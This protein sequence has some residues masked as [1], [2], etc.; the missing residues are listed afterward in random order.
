DPPT[1]VSDAYAVN[2]DNTLTVP[3]G[4]V[5]A[6]DSDPDG[7]PLTAVL[8]SGPAHGALTLNADGS[9]TY[10]PD[11]NFNGTDSFSYKANDG[12][13]DSNTTTVTINVAAVNDPPQTH[14]DVYSVAEDTTLAVAPA[15]GVLANDTDVEN[16]PLT[17]VLVGGPQHGTVT[18]NADGSFTYVPNPNF[19]G[20]DGFAY[21]A[22]DG[23][24]DSNVATVTITV[25]PVND[26]PAA[27]NDSY[28]TDEDTPLVVSTGGLLA[29]DTDVDGDPLTSILVDTPQHGT[30]TLNA[31]GTF[32][33]T[34]AA[35]Y[36]GT[37]GFT[38]KANDGTVDSN[39]AAVTITVNPVND[40]PAAINDAYTT[41]EDT[42][43]V[44]STG[45]VLANDT[46]VDGD[47]LTSILVDS[48]QHGTVTLNADGT[49]TYTSAANYNGTDGF[50]YKANDGAADSNV[51]AVTITINP[52]NDPPAAVNDSYATDED[53]PLVVSSGGVLANDTDVEG[54]PLTSILVDTPQ[55]GTVTLN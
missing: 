5:L 1:A 18:L 28:A 9:F 23:T 17:A 51:A 8:A 2:E 29:N 34:P 39:V 49:F 47:S 25:N 33:Y 45:G 7:D 15:M 22:N 14:N 41:D 11:A 53:T 30:V 26:P 20:T 24:D 38:Y 48:P 46:D 35:N 55:H 52:V 40:P 43:L 44:V 10:T 13:V 3:A 16:D 31:D 12:T 42:P 19:N 54:D 4:V 6:N 21:L 50:T 32:T 37:D 36:N 27:V